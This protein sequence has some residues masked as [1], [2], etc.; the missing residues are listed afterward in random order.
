MKTTFW[1]RYFKI[2]T[3]ILWLRLR[4]VM[5]LIHGDAVSMSHCWGWSS[6][7]LSLIPELKFSTAMRSCYVDQ[8]S[9][10]LTLVLTLLEHNSHLAFNSFFCLFVCF[11]HF[12]FSPVSVWVLAS[13]WSLLSQ[14]QDLT[15]LR[16]PLLLH[17]CYWIVTLVCMYI[18]PPLPVVFHLSIPRTWHK[19]TA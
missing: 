3:S 4:E 9:A 2:I 17:C 5:K 7:S 10:R 8:G 18:C 15:T 19:V 11:F 13:M 16:L 1:S 6:G 12:S 14:P